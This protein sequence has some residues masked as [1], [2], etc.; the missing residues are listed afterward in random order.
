MRLRPAAASPARPAVLAAREDWAV[1][2]RARSEAL[3]GCS[4]AGGSGSARPSWHAR[5]RGACVRACHRGAPACSVYAGSPEGLA[6]QLCW[7]QA[8]DQYAPDG[9]T[10]R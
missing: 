7:Q 3:P 2:A 1:L 9:C 8:A 4:R 10:A 6:A 5:G